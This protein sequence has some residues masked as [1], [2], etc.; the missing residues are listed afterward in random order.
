MRRT[1]QNFRFG[2]IANFVFC[3]RGVRED[4]V[5]PKS[6]FQKK[7]H[8]KICLFFTLENY[9]KKRPMNGWFIDLSFDK[10]V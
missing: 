8:K 1:S 4:L 10:M 5:V 6:F 7:G 9:V 2:Q 3:A